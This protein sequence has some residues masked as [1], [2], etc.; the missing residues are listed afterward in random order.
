ML[1]PLL[2]EEARYQRQL[3]VQYIEQYLDINVSVCDRCSDKK[4][5]QSTGAG[6]LECVSTSYLLHLDCCNKDVAIDSYA[7]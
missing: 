7:S 6:I 2:D 3:V 4:V 1:I 5:L